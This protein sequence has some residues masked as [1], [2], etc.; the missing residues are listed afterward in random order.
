MTAAACLGSMMAGKQARQLCAARTIDQSAIDA[1]EAVLPGK[2]VVPAE[3]T[4]TL[5]ENNKLP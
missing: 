5:R 2:P 1:L 4:A 3:M